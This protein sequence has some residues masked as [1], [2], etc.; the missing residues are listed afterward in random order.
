MTSANVIGSS[1]L[2]WPEHGDKIRVDF[3]YDRDAKT[4]LSRWWWWHKNSGWVE[5]IQRKKSM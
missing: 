3:D 5:A 2:P 1:G 4:P